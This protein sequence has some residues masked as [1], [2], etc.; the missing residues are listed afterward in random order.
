MR[1]LS[2]FGWLGVKREIA[3]DAGF[4]TAEGSWNAYKSAEAARVKS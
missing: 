2:P 1:A 3:S 4:R